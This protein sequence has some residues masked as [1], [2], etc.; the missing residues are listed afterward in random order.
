MREEGLTQAEF[1]NA[2]VKHSGITIEGIEDYERRV[3]GKV[4]KIN[5][6][7]RSETAP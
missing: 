4:S 5:G 1:L 7:K 2:L 3:F 6:V